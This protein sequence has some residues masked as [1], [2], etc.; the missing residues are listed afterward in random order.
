MTR[1]G[2]SLQ[3]A[4]TKVV[5][6]SSMLPCLACCHNAGDRIFEHVSVREWTDC[7]RFTV[8]C[9]TAN[10]REQMH[11]YLMAHAHYL[12]KCQSKLFYPN[13]SRESIKLNQRQHGD[14]A[15]VV[16]TSFDTCPGKE[17]SIRGWISLYVSLS[18]LSLIGASVDV[19]TL[20]GNED[21]YN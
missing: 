9:W 20:K 18:V 14:C 11:A 8:A 2:Q 3:P 4:Q 13:A 17:T 5:K 16:F 12:W 7:L 10:Q 15:L 6:S 19:K 21:L 1:A